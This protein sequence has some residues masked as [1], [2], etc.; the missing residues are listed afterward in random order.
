MRFNLILK[1]GRAPLAVNDETVLL[2]RVLLECYLQYAQLCLQHWILLKVFYRLLADLRTQVVFW[3]H[4]FHF[5]FNK[6]CYLCVQFDVIYICILR[7]SRSLSSM[8]GKDTANGFI[9]DVLI[10]FQGN[11]CVRVPVTGRG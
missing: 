8:Y 10:V 4:G 3:I 5:V 11:I 2:P 9:A 7:P 1:F 6:F